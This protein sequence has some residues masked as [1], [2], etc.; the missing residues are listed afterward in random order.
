MNKTNTIAVD[1]PQFVIRFSSFF[2]FQSILWQTLK[3][4]SINSI[5]I[6]RK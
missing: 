2:I 6:A 4:V 3:N 1:D 5:F